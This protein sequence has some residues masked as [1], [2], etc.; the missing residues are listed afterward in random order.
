MGPSVRVGP[1]VQIH[2]LA[3]RNLCATYAHP[4]RNISR[5]R[6]EIRLL[7]LKGHCSRHSQRI[8]ILNQVNSNFP[9][10]LHDASIKA[11]IWATFLKRSG[12]RK[13]PAATKKAPAAAKSA[14][15]TANKYIA[16]SARNLLADFERPLLAPQPTDLHDKKR[17]LFLEI[18]ST[19]CKHQNVNPGISL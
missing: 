6:R 11:R 7:T 14:P 8:C 1:W 5:I 19:R 15:V 9:R 3:M 10:A 13:A 12:K 17:G 4:M 16:H 2:I 18:R